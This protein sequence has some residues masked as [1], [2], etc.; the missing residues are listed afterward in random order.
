M[1]RRREERE[2]AVSQ[3]VQ[4][5]DWDKAIE[6]LDHDYIFAEVPDKLDI[7]Q[8]KFDMAASDEEKVKVL[9]KK[10]DLVTSDEEKVKV[11]DKKLDLVA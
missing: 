4:S 3:A 5:H 6:I 10:L 11:L 7:L 2:A 1:K 8:M 9:D